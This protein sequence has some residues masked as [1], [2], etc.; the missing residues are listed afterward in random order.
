MLNLELESK[1]YQRIVKFVTNMLAR[2]I[3][4]EDETP[5]TWAEWLGSEPELVKAAFIH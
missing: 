3:V 5:Y 1:E 4:I 2:G